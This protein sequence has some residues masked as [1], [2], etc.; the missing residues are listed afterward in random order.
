MKRK[1]YIASGFLC[2]IVLI[3]VYVVS[4]LKAKDSINLTEEEKLF[5]SENKDT[6]FMVGYYP[7]EA[8]RRFS[9]K[10]CEKIEAD[11]GL[12][13]QI[14][15]DT[16][17]DTLDLLEQ[18][19]LPAVMNMCK[20]PKREEYAYFT[21]TFLSIP[22]GIYSNQGRAITSFADIKKN[23][24]GVEREVALLDKFIMEFPKLKNSIIVYDTFE[25]TREAFLRGEISGFLSTKSY[26]ADVRGLY[27]FPM[28]SITDSSNHIGV[29]KDMPILYSILHKE[30]AFLKKQDWDIWVADIINFE[31]EKSLVAFDE[32]EKEFIKQNER[33]TVG[34]PN[35]YFLY[36][37]GNEYTQEGPLAEILQK[38]E[39][40]SGI[41]ID[42]IFDTLEN[43]RLRNDV[44][45]YLDYEYESK[46]ATTT[47]FV[48]EMAIVSKADGRYI[49]EVYELAHYRIGVFGTPNAGEFLKERMPNIMVHEY[50]EIEEVKKKMKKNELDYII[51]PRMYYETT[52]IVND[53][54]LRG[55]FDVTI[56][57]FVS[58]SLIWI[59][60]LDK[61]LGIMDTEKMIQKGLVEEKATNMYVIVGAILV[62][63]IL[64]LVLSRYFF[65][66][67]NESVYRNNRYKLY[68]LRYLSKKVLSK[69]EVK[70]LMMIE[71][72]ESEKIRFHYGSKVYDRHFRNISMQINEVLKEKNHVIFG[73]SKYLVVPFEKMESAKRLYQKTKGF[74][75]ILLNGNMIKCKLKC[76]VMDYHK[77]DNIYENMDFVELAMEK[78]EGKEELAYYSYDDHKRY[79]NKLG[80]RVKLEKRIINKEVRITEKRIVDE[81]GTLLGVYIEPKIDGY[82]ESYIAKNIKETDLEMKLDKQVVEK[83]K[84]KSRKGIVFLRIHISTLRSK[85]FF[86]W[87]EKELDENQKIVVLLQAKEIKEYGEHLVRGKNIKYGVQ[88]FGQQLSTD[89]LMK[90]YPM[91]YAFISNEFEMEYENDES[92]SYIRKYTKEHK[93]RTITTNRESHIW[94]FYIQEI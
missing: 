40:I 24:I 41:E 31:L 33:V 61:C 79:K 48:D 64:L 72:E 9:K 42:Y 53:Y 52:D 89:L 30:V 70:Y 82:T 78:V 20:I 66:R 2:I 76:V 43:L 45:F 90:Y 49:D 50:K 85:D 39:F 15:E 84:E 3:T 60:V 46:Y 92:I 55:K 10:L 67:Y 22:C 34:I 59:D 16:W 7:T 23:K 11:T 74:Q 77:E 36:G 56:H 27:F 75:G 86:T 19:E 68:N 47:V 1:L 91:E 12:K 69:M 17:N 37:N 29:T 21:D 88:D 8:E 32:K 63:V 54:S 87:L 25:E 83:I 44:D 57:R 65:N 28:E 13:L 35:E 58:N 51:I 14:Y 4:F 38:I 5:I 62:V 71:I 26:D 80:H 93:I 73:N 18:G 6:V 81:T 94:D